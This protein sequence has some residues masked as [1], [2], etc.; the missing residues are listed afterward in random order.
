MLG[1]SNTVPTSKKPL[2]SAGPGPGPGPSGPQTYQVQIENLSEAPLAL[3]AGI[4]LNSGG[5][6]DTGTPATTI[7]PP[8]TLAIIQ[9]AANN[10]IN[11]DFGGATFPITIGTTEAVITCDTTVPMEAAGSATP[12]VIV[13]IAGGVSLPASVFV[14][15]V[16]IETV[17]SPKINVN[18]VTLP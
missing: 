12:M 5:L 14:D 1:N 6:F 17:A 8:N 13:S 11:F 4:Q 2:G 18:Y 16:A 9:T 15:G 7:N 10:V 3:I